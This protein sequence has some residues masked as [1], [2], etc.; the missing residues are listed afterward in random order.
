MLSQYRFNGL[1]YLAGGVEELGLV[2]VT[3]YHQIQNFFDVRFA[4]CH[5]DRSFACGLLPFF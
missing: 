5:W 4:V 2:R 1:K 3:L